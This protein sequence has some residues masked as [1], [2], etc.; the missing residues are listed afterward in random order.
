MS[1]ASLTRTGRGARRLGP[2]GPAEPRPDGTAPRRSA[3]PW[4]ALALAAL[5]VASVVLFLV[6][7]TFPNYDSY[8]SLLWG[9]EVLDGHLPSF[10]A[11]RAP[12]QHPLAVGFGALLSLLGDSADRVMVGATLVSFVV[13]AVG[14]YRLGR[15]SFGWLVGLVAAGLLCTRFDFPFLAARGYIDIPYLAFVVWAAALE[16]EQRRRGVPVLLLLVGAGLLRPEAWLLSG[17][18]WLWLFP[19]LGWSGRVRTAVLVALGPAVWIATDWIV[20][21]DPLF[22]HTHTSGLAEELG[23]Q[24]A[25]SEVPRTTWNFLIGLDKA[26]VFYAGLLGVV[27]AVV[28]VPRRVGVALGLL[29]AGLATFGLVGVAGLSVIDRYLLVPSLM[30]MVFAAVTLAG[31]TMLRAGVARRV[32]AVAALL[33]VGYGVLFTASRVRLGSFDTELQLRGHSHAALEAL[34]RNPRVRAGRTCGPISVPNH[35]LVPD[36]RWIVDGGVDDVVARS[37]PKQASRIRR[38]VAVYVTDRAALL[39]QALVEDSDDP[40]DS[41]PMAGFRR[42]ATTAYY[43]AY[44]R[45]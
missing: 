45:C 39:R 31:W 38:G 3:G 26:P 36:V 8:Y 33:V 13:L 2:E 37:D 32:W 4:P 16:A 25:L 9:R 10:D 35:K 15:A 30:V 22:S 20:T 42:V 12:T 40:L 14:L 11:Y 23:R 6:Y 17:L 21:G 5:L 28:L 29:V 44:V 41:V 43:G 7:P 24:R 1:S 34:L 18:Y 27:L 19:A